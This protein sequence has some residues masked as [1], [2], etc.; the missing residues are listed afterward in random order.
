MRHFSARDLKDYLANKEN[1][2]LLLDVRETWEYNHCHIEG[3]ELIPMAQIPSAVVELDP[4]RATVVIC[5]HGIR[6]HQVAHYLQQ[7]GF[8]DLINLDGGMESWARHVD[9]TMKRY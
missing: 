7:Q 1:T 8:I 6:S 2:P 9:P 3:S 4:N 5:H